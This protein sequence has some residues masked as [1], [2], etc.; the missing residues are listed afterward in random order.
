VLR[1][2][3]YRYIIIIIYKI[4]QW[5]YLRPSATYFIGHSSVYIANQVKQKIK[6]I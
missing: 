1:D 4:L 3:Q 6:I 5:L 2:V